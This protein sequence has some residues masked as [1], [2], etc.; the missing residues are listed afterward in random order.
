MEPGTRWA[1]GDE[2]GWGLHRCHQD[3][4]SSCNRLQGWPGEGKNPRAEFACRSRAPMSSWA[5]SFPSTPAGSNP[6]PETLGSQRRSARLAAGLTLQQ[7]ADRDGV[8]RQAIYQREQVIGLPPKRLDLK[9]KEYGWWTALKRT[10]PR[11]VLCV[12]RCGVKKEIHLNS[13][14]GGKSRSC[15]KCGYKKGRVGRPRKAQ[16]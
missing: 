4:A 15:G 6:M 10:G 14:R 12:C 16:A 1:S 2:W 8:T 9:G 13:L 11:Y 5:V 7:V 3:A